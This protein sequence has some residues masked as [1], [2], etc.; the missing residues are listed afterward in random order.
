MAKRYMNNAKNVNIGGKALTSVQSFNISETAQ[1]Q[2][3][4]GDGDEFLS[5]LDVGVATHV[6][7]VVTRDLSHGVTVSNT[8]S[9]A[10]ATIEDQNDA[11]ITQTLTNVKIHSVDFST[12]HEGEATS[13]IVGTASGD[14]AS[15]PLSTS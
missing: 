14:G 11:E 7:T 12:S 10:S 4:S 15:T 6:V 8:P 5:G 1:V 13:T 3:G 2:S 9:N